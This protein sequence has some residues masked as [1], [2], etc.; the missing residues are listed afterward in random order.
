MQMN[1]FGGMGRLANCERRLGPSGSQNGGRRA[2]KSP[3]E[4]HTER[5]RERERDTRDVPGLKHLKT[6]KSE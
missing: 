3:R 1:D 5:E 4:R 2:R 6:L